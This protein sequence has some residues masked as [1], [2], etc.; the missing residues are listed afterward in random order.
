M[1]YKKNEKINLTI[2]WIDSSLP[3][4]IKLSFL[5]AYLVNNQ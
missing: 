1:I 5:K 2:I 4:K 3:K